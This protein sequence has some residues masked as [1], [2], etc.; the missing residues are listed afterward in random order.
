MHFKPN[1]SVAGVENSF[2]FICTAFPVVVR[3][4]AVHQ[5]LQLHLHIV[6]TF[7]FFETRQYHIHAWLESGDFMIMC[8][9]FCEL[10]WVAIQPGLH[11]HPPFFK[12]A[13]Q[14]TILYDPGSWNIST[15]ALLPVPPPPAAPAPAHVCSP[16]SS[17][18]L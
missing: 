12:L 10:F 18:V 8:V 17:Q 13:G 2:N 16:R 7:R 14:A 9:L 11:L 5:F 4:H 1:L 15:L 3:Q 6:G